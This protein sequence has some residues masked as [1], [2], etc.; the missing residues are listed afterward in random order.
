MSAELEL[1]W[2][3]EVVAR[4]APAFFLHPAD[5]YMPCT[6][7]YFMRHSELRQAAPSTSDGGSSSVLLPRGCIAAPGLL[8]AQRAA[9]PGARLQLNLDPAARCGMPLSQLDDVPIYA[10]PKLI[11]GAHGGVEAL[12]ISF[13][14][15]YAYNGEYRVGGLPFLTTGAHD[16]DWEH[17][18][19]RV[20]PT[21]GKLLGM[22]YNAHRSRDGCWV[23]GLEVPRDPASGRVAAFVAL[24]GHGTY[25]QAGRVLRHFFLGNDLCSGE[26]PIWRPRHVVLLP[27]LHEEAAA[28]ATGDAPAAVGASVRHGT[29]QLDDAPASGQEEADGGG[30]D[31]LQA[32]LSA[33]HLEP[34]QQQQQ[35]QQQH[36]NSQGRQDASNG[37]HR[38]SSSAAASASIKNGNGGS[39]RVEVAGGRRRL[40]H[41][42]SRGSSLSA[43]GGSGSSSVTNLVETAANRSTHMAAG[44]ASAATPA[45]IRSGGNNGGGS[46]LSVPQVIVDDPCEWVFFR[47]EW[48]TTPAPICQSWFHRAEPPLSRTSLQ[49]LFGHFVSEPA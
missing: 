38:R 7:E 34:L 8:E 15:L 21:S 33:L 2:L 39:G 6:A 23:G 17:C 31:G 47:G 10:H 20:H 45:A 41:A 26:G 36:E 9:P 46:S 37:Q 29:V 13:L 40:V 27:P 12:E 32:G 18:T 43:A 4:H 5:R 30:V 11:R 16:G 35:Q 24:H 48:G 28:A 3:C 42:P 1:E 49:R 19:A 22:W 14:T 25:P 44:A